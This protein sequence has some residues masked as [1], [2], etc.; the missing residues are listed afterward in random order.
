MVPKAE[1]ESVA[2]TAKAKRAAFAFAYW[3]L[4]RVSA[5]LG[6]V[7]L[8]DELGFVSVAVASSSFGVSSTLGILRKRR[9]RMMKR[10][11]SRPILPLPICSCRSTREPRAVLESLT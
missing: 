11:A 1:V 5:G 8:G 9:S 2:R 6:A 3:G 7:F 10:K 4:Q